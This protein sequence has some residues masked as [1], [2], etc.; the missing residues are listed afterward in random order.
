VLGTWRGGRRIDLDAFLA[1]I[2]AVDPSQ[3]A[4]LGV[5]HQKCC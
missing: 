3:H 4:H 5:P 1:E 2:V